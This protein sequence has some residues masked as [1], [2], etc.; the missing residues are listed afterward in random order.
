MGW[1]LGATDQIGSR[2]SEYLA[3]IIAYHNGGGGPAS[4][5]SVTVVDGVEDLRTTGPVNGLPSIL[6]MPSTRAIAAGANIIETVV[7]P[8]PCSAD[9]RAAGG[10]PRRHRALGRASRSHQTV[11]IRTSVRDVADHSC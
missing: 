7:E 6:L 8:H 11:T 3:L 5:T 9:G 2:P 1:T 4:A 10:D